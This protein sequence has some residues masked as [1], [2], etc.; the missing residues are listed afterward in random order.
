MIKRPAFFHTRKSF[1]KIQHFKEIS[2]IIIEIL[3]IVKN[4]NSNKFYVDIINKK[5]III[6]SEVGVC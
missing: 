2:K 4:T 1:G 3:L 6:G 5:Y